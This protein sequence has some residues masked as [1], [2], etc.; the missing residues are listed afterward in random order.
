M[1]F[2]EKYMVRHKWKMEQYASVG[3]V[4]WDNLIVTYNDIYGNLDMRIIESE[5]VNKLL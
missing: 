5:I 2:D 1:P 4:P 3:I